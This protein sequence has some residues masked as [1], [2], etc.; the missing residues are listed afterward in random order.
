M[1]TGLSKEDSLVTFRHQDSVCCCRVGLS[2]NECV[3]VKVTVA[4][5]T[6]NSIIASGAGDEGVV[7]AIAFRHQVRALIARASLGVTRFTLFVN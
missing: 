1:K 3:C 2:S 5:R 6:R 7:G 4:G